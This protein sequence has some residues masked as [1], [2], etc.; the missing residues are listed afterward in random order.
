MAS[1][2]KVNKNGSITIPQQLRHEL[3]IKA[4]VPL[5]IEA[6]E[7]GLHL[8]KY[9]PTCMLCGSAEQVVEIDG[10]GICTKCAEEVLRRYKA[11]GTEGA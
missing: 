1:Y 10:F 5:E 6:T 9:I 4:G 7:N 2:K 11:D 8:K 3:G